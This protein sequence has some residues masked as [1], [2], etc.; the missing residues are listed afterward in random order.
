MATG[1]SGQFT[2]RGYLSAV[3]HTALAGIEPTTFRL[4]VRRSTSCATET[5][6]R[7]SKYTR[8]QL[9]GDVGNCYYRVLYGRAGHRSFP[10]ALHRFI[11]LKAALSP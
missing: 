5:T 9:R 6:H 1:H 8:Q 7:P 11:K 2:R 10:A 4:L 3:K